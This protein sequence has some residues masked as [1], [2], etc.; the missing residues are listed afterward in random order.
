[1]DPGQISGATLPTAGTGRY[2]EG[3][4]ALTHPP[5]LPSRNPQKADPAGGVIR[6]QWLAGER[7]PWFV[8]FYAVPRSGAPG[9]FPLR[10]PGAAA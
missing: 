3:T 1:M 10:E 5:N 7:R 4:A 2:A 8:P 6:R 9:F